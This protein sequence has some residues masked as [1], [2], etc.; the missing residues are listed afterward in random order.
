M[1]HTLKTDSIPFMEVYRGD[2]TFELR[3][4]DR[5]FKEGDYLYLLETSISGGTL[6]LY[7]GQFI[8]AKITSKLRDQYGLPADLC[9][10]SIKVLD[11]GYNTQDPLVHKAAPVVY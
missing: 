11:K 6:M 7:T 3:K 5:N 8:L 9:I 1:I 2:K 4:D 10:L